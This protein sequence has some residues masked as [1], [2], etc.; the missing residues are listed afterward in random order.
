VKFNN[1]HDIAAV[2]GATVF[3]GP[4]GANLANPTIGD[5]GKARRIVSTKDH[6]TIIGGSGDRSKLEARVANV[7]T[8]LAEAK[9][10][11]DKD[12]LQ[13]RLAKLV[14]GVSLIKVGGATES[15]VKETKQRVEDA[16]QA[17]VAAAEEGVLPGGGNALAVIASEM[18]EGEPGYNVIRRALTAPVATILGNAGL[19][20]RPADEWDKGYDVRTMQWKDSLMAAGIIDPAKVARVALQN[21]ASIASTLITSSASITFVEKAKSSRDV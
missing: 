13:D 3:S 18:G 12:K 6:T 11:F 2:T 14:G 7:K 16:V 20:A 8:Q 1:C 4:G 15:E 21:A 19:T 17:T 10:H 5:F 9:S